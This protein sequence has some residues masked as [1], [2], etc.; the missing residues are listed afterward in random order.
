MVREKNGSLWDKILKQDI[1][2]QA[3]LVEFMGWI[4]LVGLVI[5]AGLF[6]TVKINITVPA[7]EAKLIELPSRNFV[8][9]TEVS[10]HHASSISEKQRVNLKFLSIQGKEIEA[11]GKIVEIQPK[12]NSTALIIKVKPDLDTKTLET[13]SQNLKDIRLRIIIQRKRLTSLFIEKK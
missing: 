6:W 10:E 3:N 8:V 9:E 7:I 2:R 11:S 4:G 1:D 12:T 13:L 5:L